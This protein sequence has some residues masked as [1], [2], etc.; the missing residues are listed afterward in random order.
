MAREELL[1]HLDQLS[2]RNNALTL[3]LVT[4]HIEE[5]HPCISHVMLL[6]DGHVLEHGQTSDVLTNRLLSDAFGGS[7][8]V[9]HHGDRY[10]LRSSRH[11]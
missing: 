8:L 9:D 2:Q 6:K 7:C 3:I 4:H 1:H 10:Y 11:R 5:I